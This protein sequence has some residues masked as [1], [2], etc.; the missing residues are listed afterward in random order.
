MILS[1]LRAKCSKGPMPSQRFP[2]E[3]AEMGEAYCILAIGHPPSLPCNPDLHVLLEQITATIKS[4]SPAR[5]PDHPTTIPLMLSLLSYLHSPFKPPKPSTSAN[6]PKWLLPQS[7]VPTW[8]IN[9][10]TALQSLYTS[11]LDPGGSA[12]K[13]LAANAGDTGLIPDPGRSHM[14]WSNWA[15]VPQRLSLCSRAWGLQ[16]LCSC[17]A[18]PKAHTPKAL[19]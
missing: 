19:V 7:P 6:P 5:L 12:V 2:L 8:P 11:F 13:N 15:L 9:S 18:I 14:P 17:A 3:G 4:R 10:M 1:V 16:L